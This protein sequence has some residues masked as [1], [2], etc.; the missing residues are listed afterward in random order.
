MLNNRLSY[1]FGLANGHLEEAYRYSV[2]ASD[3][4]IGRGA[5]SDA[6]IFIQKAALSAQTPLEVRVIIT[7]VDKAIQIVSPSIIVAN[8]RKTIDTF[9]RLSVGSL[10]ISIKYDSPSR[11]SVSYDVDVVRAT[12]KDIRRQL[13]ATLTELEIEEEE[14]DKKSI[15]RRGDT[16]ADDRGFLGGIC[17]G[18]GNNEVVYQGQLD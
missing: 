13:E 16:R 10:S 14:A 6:I 8:V 18:L 4:C 1:H 5:H 3:D 9:R 7:I 17:F 2:E 11:R 15:L 12:Y